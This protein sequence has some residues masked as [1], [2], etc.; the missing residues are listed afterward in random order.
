MDGK[1]P[2]P[3]FVVPEL[4]TILGVSE[5][6]LLARGPVRGTDGGSLAPAIWFKLRA[7]NLAAAD[8]E[9]VGLVRRLGFFMAQFEAIRGVRSSPP[10]G[11]RFR[12]RFWRKLIAPLPRQFKGGT[13][14]S[15]FARLPI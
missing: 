6:R 14:L 10:R 5:K 1:R 15:V 12:R 13:P 2:I 3:Q 7:D 9:F 4:S 8:R 11:A